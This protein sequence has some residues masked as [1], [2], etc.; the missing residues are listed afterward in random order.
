MK[1]I[2]ILL[3]ALLAT[4]MIFQSCET[5][6]LDLTGNPNA[7]TTDQTDVDFF[8]N[9]IQIRYANLMEKFGTTSAQVV[10]IEYLG[11]RN[12]LNAFAPT[13][14]DDEWDDAYREILADV[15]AMR[16]IALENEQY[17]H[18][19]IAQVLS[20]DVLV[21]LVDNF[22][23]IPY[24][25][26]LQGADDLLNPNVDSGVA[27]YSA[28]EGMLN[29]AISNFTRDG[30]Q[31]G[32]DTDLFYDNDYDLWVKLANTLKMK[33]YLQT[34]LVD[35]D[36]NSKFNAIVAAGNYITDTSEDFEF[37]WGT[38][39]NQ[40]DT[41]APKYADNYTPTGAGDY[42]SNWLIGTMQDK[43]DPRLRYYFYRQV[44][45]V[46]GEEVPPNEQTLTCSLENAPQH[47]IDGGFTFCSLP[48][49]YWA[50]D[51]G[52]NDG[53]PGDGFLRSTYGV[54]PAGGNFDDSRFDPVTQG[55][56]GAGAGI[57]PLMLAS[58][59]DFMKAEMAYLENPATAEE[60]IIAGTQKSIAKVRSFG[61][62]D[63]SA[64][65]S[66]APSDDDVS[67]YLD[68]VAS[69][70]Q[71]ATETGKWNVMAEQFW[72]AS[73]GN[74]TLNYNFYRRTGYPT[75]LQPN[76]EFNPGGF[77]RS[78]RYP[79]NFVNNNSSVSQK[80]DVTAQVFWDTNPPSPEF[81]TS[82]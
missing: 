70:Y 76:R 45:A 23:D 42:L 80:Q 34:R 81:P 11:S 43:D 20:A 60:F 5:T 59:V 3:T 55:G 8:N 69:D 68:D 33:I 36:A 53:T 79:A 38:N 24:S 12:Y 17:R 73:F 32:P 75:T 64:D 35:A 31:P 72:I 15:Q 54:Y 22:G 18:L 82:N 25:E 7:L 61:S 49:G 30:S 66:V 27:V 52:D 14:F 6:D 71:S 48:N 19:A 29:D 58:W 4:G 47:Y 1:R 13:A 46:P 37:Q 65:L 77:I 50:R 44:N 16:P 21:T 67:T 9:A 40:P 39:E 28:A 10:R 74:G 51:H 26:A 2:Y 57:T 41:R 63:G 56:G 78:F 62:L